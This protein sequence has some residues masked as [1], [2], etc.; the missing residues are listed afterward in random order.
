MVLKRR[1][2]GRVALVHF[3]EGATSRGD[4]H[5]AMNL[6]AVMKL[7]VIF[8]C[9]NNGYAYSTPTEKQFAVKNL[10]VRGPAY[11][12]PG[13]TVDGNDVRA[14]F[15]AAARAIERARAGE[16]PTFIECKTFRLTGHSAHDMAEYVPD[17]LL[18]RWERRDPILLLEKFL[19]VRR[20]LARERIHEMGEG[21]RKEIDDAVAFAE[22]NPFPRGETTLEGLYCAADCWWK[23]A[24]AVVSGQQSVAA[25]NGLGTEKKH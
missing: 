13:V 24:P 23:E 14:V 2:Q 18:K 19:L 12:M 6:A 17:E 22:S 16:G 10:S 11:G 3:G 8:I 1:G 7:P 5:E 25:R 21:I 15:R 20:L 4:V 9:N